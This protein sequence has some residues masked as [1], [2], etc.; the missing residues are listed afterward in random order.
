M[1][2]EEAF[3]ADIIE[4]PDDDGPR[5]IF[6]DWLEDHDQADRAAFIRVQ[7]EL[8]ALPHDDPRR[9]GLKTTERRLQEQHERLWAAPLS[10]IASDWGFRRG[11]VELVA[12]PAAALARHAD[13]I[14]QSAPVRALTLECRLGRDGLRRLLALPYLGRL[15]ELGLAW[16]GIDA[17]GLRALAGCPRLAGLASLNLADNGLADKAV[18]A[19]LASPHLSALR[20][21]DLSGN[22]LSE[23]QREALRQRFGWAAYRYPP[24]TDDDTD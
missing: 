9:P 14:F 1:T 12:L 13:A 8:A 5:L 18:A 24:Q 21:I 6:A 23:P 16:T 20:A 22:P 17:N 7:I 3:L 4:S 10:E 15:R 11:L 19:L 2:P